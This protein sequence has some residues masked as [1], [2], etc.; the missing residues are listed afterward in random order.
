MIF[1]V[2]PALVIIPILLFRLPRWLGSK[3]SGKW[4]VVGYF[5]CLLGYI[6]VDIVFE[7]AFYT[8][9][10][11]RNALASIGLNLR[12]DFKISYNYSSSDIHGK[13]YHELRLK[14]STV[15]RD[16]L[17]K[18]IRTSK[19]FVTDTSKLINFQPWSPVKDT[20]F[21]IIEDYEDF[22]KKL[23]FRSHFK[24]EGI[25]RPTYEHIQIDINIAELRFEEYY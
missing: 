7:D 11:A 25:H 4:V 3:K 12:H 18:Q 22:D 20:F 21:E 5:I 19:Y 24:S 6:G 9:S 13:F 23:V 2:I 1:T 16:N 14:I 15:D 10:D 17:E 8:K